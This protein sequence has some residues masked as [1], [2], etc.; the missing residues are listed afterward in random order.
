VKKLYRCLRLAAAAALLSL[1]PPAG[2]IASA[3][4]QSQP[5]IVIGVVD[6]E[7]IMKESKAGN[8]AKSQYDKRISAFNA[9]L[10]QKRKAFKDQARKLNAKQ[11]TL[12]DDEFKKKVDELD[13]QGKAIEKSLVQAK[14]A[15][16]TKFTKG[17][18]QIRS[19]LLEIVAKI[20]K[21]RALTLVLNKSHVIVAADA[22]DLTDESMKRLDATMPSV[23]LTGAN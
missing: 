3:V 1:A 12:P 19:A 14:Q 6:F 9:E 15:L 5:G 22:Y 8:S 23:N 21:E 16:D 11:S 20:A 2:H 18:G 4:A 13:A 7:F 10:E 17:V